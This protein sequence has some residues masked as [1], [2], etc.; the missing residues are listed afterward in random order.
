[1][2]ETFSNDPTISVVMVKIAAQLFNF[3]TFKGCVSAPNINDRP[4]RV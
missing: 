4:Y 1:L 2:T 3:M